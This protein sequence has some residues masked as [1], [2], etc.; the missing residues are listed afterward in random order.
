MMAS[1]YNTDCFATKW[2]LWSAFPK[3]SRASLTGMLLIDSPNQNSLQYLDSECCMI[4]PKCC[5]SLIKDADSQLTDSASHAGLQA[6]CSK[7]IA[8]CTHFGAYRNIQFSIWTP[9]PMK[10]PFWNTLKCTYHI[11]VRMWIQQSKI[12]TI[13]K[14]YFLTFCKGMFLQ[15]QY[16]IDSE[17][18]VTKQTFY[19]EFNHMKFQAR[20]IVCFWDECLNE[21]PM[22]VNI[23]RWSEELSET[24]LSLL[25]VDCFLVLVYMTHQKRSSGLLND[26]SRLQ[27]LHG[28]SEHRPLYDIRRLALHEES[29]VIMHLANQIINC[30]SF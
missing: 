11:Q 14:K 27:L 20:N 21:L 3:M 2:S 10:Q 4:S 7:T 18:D 28:H 25:Y 1:T 8:N 23:T 26:F 19:L 22:S 29:Y 12:Q 5:E 16:K 15:I 13:L 6:R 17:A 9:C 30:C 24:V